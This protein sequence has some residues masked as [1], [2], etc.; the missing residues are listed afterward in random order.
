[1]EKKVKSK[2]K[3]KNNR[4]KKVTKKEIE[5][6]FL[7]FTFL[8]ATISVLAT[9]LKSYT[10]LLFGLNITFSVF[11]LPCILF[12]SNYITKKEGFKN[13]L[14][15][16]IIST[17]MVK[18]FLFLIENLTN[19]KANV[20]E[21]LG[22]SL[23]NFVSLFINLAIYYYILINLS[24]KSIMVEL[25]YMFAFIL[26]SFINLLFL[27]NLAF[28]NNFWGQFKIAIVIQFIISIVLVCFDRKIERGIE[29]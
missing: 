1:M 4:K 20:M 14:Y 25:N 8:L 22:Y 15:A 18:A 5:N 9:S 21:I 23:S 16:V 12:I 28:T 27:N 13:S 24:Y 7:L 3:E 10:F 29:K 2:T 6:E 17:L 26:N 11:V 19:Q